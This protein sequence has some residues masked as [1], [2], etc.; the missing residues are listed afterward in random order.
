[1]HLWNDFIGL[2]KWDKKFRIYDLMVEDKGEK[3][4]VKDSKKNK[5]EANKAWYHAVKKKRQDCHKQKNST[6]LQ[7]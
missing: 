1:M 5:I 2:L 3:T 6:C 4:E 7:L